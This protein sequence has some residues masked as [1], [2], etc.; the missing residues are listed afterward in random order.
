MAVGISPLRYILKEQNAEPQAG[1]CSA[2]V[3]TA[4]TFSDVA[5]AFY[6]PKELRHK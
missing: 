1:V 3:K 6:I 5:K 4:K 2:L